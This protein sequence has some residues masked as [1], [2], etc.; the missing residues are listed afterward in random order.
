MKATE[1]CFPVVNCHCYAGCLSFLFQCTKGSG[2]LILQHFKA[3]P[4]YTLN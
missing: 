2:N 4:K 3:S 1:Q